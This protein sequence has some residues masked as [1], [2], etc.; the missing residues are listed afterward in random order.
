M[1]PSTSLPATPAV[2]QIPDHLLPVFETISGMSPME[3]WRVGASILIPL[4][5]LDPTGF[6]KGDP[7]DIGEMFRNQIKAT[8]EWFAIA[9]DLGR[10]V[11]DHKLM[12]IALMRI[13]AV[14]LVGA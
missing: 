12:A 14:R 9:N 1:Q 6:R 4:G 2:P 7:E 13:A 10:F 5:V 8:P 11:N 3:C